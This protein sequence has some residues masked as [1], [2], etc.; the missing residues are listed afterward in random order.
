MT[1]GR[2]R[3]VQKR[4]FASVVGYLSSVCLAI[5]NGRFH[6]TSMYNDLHKQEGWDKNIKIKLSNKSIQELKHFWLQPC[7]S[8][9]GRSWFPP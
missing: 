4:M 7:R 3:V 6:L 1:L 9:I 5:P 2:A 8:E